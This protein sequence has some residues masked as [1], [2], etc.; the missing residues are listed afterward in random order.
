MQV[1]EEDVVNARD[2]YAHGE[3]VLDAAGAEVEEEAVAVA[4]L[5]HDARAGLIAPLRKRPFSQQHAAAFS[6]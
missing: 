1:G 5:D 6:P 2:R 3:D 4:K